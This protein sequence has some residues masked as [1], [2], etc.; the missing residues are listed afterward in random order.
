MLRLN[1]KL[2]ARFNFYAYERSFMHCLYFICKRN[3]Y[4][5]TH[6][7]ITRHWKST[8]RVLKMAARG[9]T[10]QIFIW[11]GSAPKFNPLPFYI[12][13]FYEKGT[14]FVY[15]LLTKWY[16]SY[17]PYPELCIPFNCCQEMHRLL[18]ENQSQK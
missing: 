4:S 11:G 6:V 5:C 8:L 13:F 12:S 9:G 3:F 10:Q 17:V 2:T 1:E 18:N 14:P 16:P 7:K 15:L